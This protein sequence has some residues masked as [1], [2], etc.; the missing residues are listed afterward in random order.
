MSIPP[1]PGGRTDAVRP[2][3]FVRTSF[4]DPSPPPG[5]GIGAVAWMRE[6]LFSTPA[7]AG[8]TIITALLLYWAVPPMIQ[9]LFID[10]VWT[11][12]NREA[13]LATAE[14]PV[15]ACWAFVNAKFAQ[16]MYG[17]Y[18]LDERWRVDLTGIVFAVGLFMLAVPKIPFKRETTIFMLA[19]FPVLAYFLLYGGLGLT[20]V[21]TSLWGGL[22]VTMVVAVS[23]IVASL[24]LG[25][26]LALGRRSKLP[27]VKTFSV[28]FIEFWR[29]VPLIT[30]LFMASVM[31][32]L[33]L[34]SGVNFD[35]LLRALIGVALFSAAY[36]AET[37]RG[38]LQA[39]P[40]G[41]YEAGAAV[42]LGYWQTMLLIVLPQALK[43]VIPGIVN[44]FISLFKDTSL[45]L[46]IG[47]FDVLGIIQLN[48]TDSNWTSPN[49]PKTGFIFAALVFWIFCFGMSRYSQ[50]ME[51]RLETGHKRN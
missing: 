31:L 40:K 7:N 23:G 15:G 49:V 29:G 44:S 37:V 2:G 1:G 42:G 24:P 46:I 12:E 11:G 30:V 32:P 19:V 21:E 36:M 27:I 18:P 25:I 28:I 45:V 39:I 41:Q 8:I 47:L 16:F 43:I 6:N 5:L 10:A 3:G 48:F 9:W 34:P 14:R 51:R 4:V 26:L 50:Y 17:R 33:F 13:C 20:V 35:K 22:L 38:G